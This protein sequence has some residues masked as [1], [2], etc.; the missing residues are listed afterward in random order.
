MFTVTT[1]VDAVEPCVRWPSRNNH[2]KTIYS[3]FNKACKEWIRN[4][5]ELL[6]FQGLSSKGQRQT[7]AHPHRQEAPRDTQKPDPH[8]TCAPYHAAA[9]TCRYLLV[10]RLRPTHTGF[11]SSIEPSPRSPC[12]LLLLGNAYCTCLRS[13]TATTYQCLYA[14]KLEVRSPHAIDWW[15]TR[16]LARELPP[17]SQHQHAME[18]DTKKRPTSRPR[19]QHP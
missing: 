13:C 4:K 6:L 16:A 17:I 19:E 2:L 18:H 15:S 10:P 5:E 1:T 3:Q 9:V 8:D 14:L 12:V 11:P 7:T